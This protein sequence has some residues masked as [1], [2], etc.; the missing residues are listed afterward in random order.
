MTEELIPR[1]SPMEDRQQTRMEDV[2]ELYRQT[3][4]RLAVELALHIEDAE[5]I[6]ARYN[7]TPEQAAE[8]CESPVFVMILQRATK[9]VQT[10]GLS[11]K[12]KAQ[13]IAGEL[14]PYAHDL[15]TDP[16]VSAAVRLDSIKWTAKVAG[17]DK[18]KDDQKSAGGFSLSI[19]FAG[20][21]PKTIVQSREPVTLIQEE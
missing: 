20:E 16:L 5:E 21:A 7:Y 2:P 8:L 6:F 10:S 3:H 11:F 19:T 9:E 14:L 1:E 17:F 12:T 13:L 18:E 15:A 4:E